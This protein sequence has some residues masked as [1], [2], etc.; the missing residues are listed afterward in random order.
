[1][2]VGLGL[3]KCFS[4]LDQDQGFEKLKSILLNST[5]DCN[6][7]PL[8]KW[9]SLLNCIPSCYIFRNLW[10]GEFKWMYFELCCSLIHSVKACCLHKCHLYK[11]VA[12]MILLYSRVVYFW[13]SLLLV[14][15]FMYIEKK[16]VLPLT[17]FCYYW[18]FFTCVLNAFMFYLGIC[19]NSWKISVIFLQLFWDF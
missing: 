16:I 4:G 1:M 17:A 18:V 10:H 12:K 11:S 14:K 6:F 7:L 5:G 13:H 15:I 9:D 3:L 8:Q 19:I 2:L